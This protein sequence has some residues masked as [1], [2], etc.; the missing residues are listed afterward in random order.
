VLAEGWG[1]VGGGKEGEVYFF[2][3]FT[4]GFGF[5]AHGDPFRVSA[6][7]FPVSVG[8]VTAGVNEDV[9]EHVGLLW[10]VGGSPEGESPHVVPRE[11]SDGVVAETRE[12]LGQFAFDDVIDAEFVDGR[13][14][15]HWVGLF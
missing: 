3:E 14:R 10:I 7:G 4:V 13:V 11:D 12:K 15:W 6:E 5:V 1:E 2:D 9:D 8:S